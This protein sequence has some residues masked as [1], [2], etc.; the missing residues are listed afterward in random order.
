MSQ[1]TAERDLTRRA[2]MGTAAAIGAILALDPQTALAVTAAEKQAEADAVRNQLVSLKADLELAASQYYGA[3]D[4]KEAAEASMQQEQEKIDQATVRIGQLKERL[5]NRAVSMYRS[6]PTG[7]LDF[8]LGSSSFQQFSENWSLI[9]RVN[10]EDARLVEETKQQ[11]RALQDAKDEFARQ[12]DVAAAKADE[13][14][15]IRA[16]VE[17]RVAESQKLLDSL[18][19][20]AR[21]LLAK[22]QAEEAARR[23]REEE[24]TRRRAQ[25]AQPIAP[26]YDHGGGTPGDYSAVVG[27][28]MSRIGC[29]YVWGDG[30]PS[31][32]DCSG[33]VTWSYAQIGVYIPHQSEAQ[34]AAAK[35]RVPV[36]EARPGD[37]LWRWGHVGIAVSPGGTH[38]VH[39]P[40]EGLLVRDTDPLSWSAFTHALQF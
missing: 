11:K 18:S 28:A 33:L 4:A 2:F 10:D 13:A 39:A 19:G 31:T 21:E 34:Y 38:Y 12:K 5:G 32:F 14:A 29:P 27:Y 22:E 16:Q 30:G 7:F 35:R 3:L 24:E 9:N 25:P 26:N 17:E 1:Q 36:S 20:E 23:A 15:A 37:V 40:D 8:I 6:G